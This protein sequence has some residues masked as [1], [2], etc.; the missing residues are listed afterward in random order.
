MKQVRELDFTGEKIFCDIDVHK[1]SWKVCVRNKYMEF[2]TFLQPPSATVLV[3]YLQKNFPS[4]DYYAAYEAGFC[5]F[6]FQRDFIR[7]G[8][9][10]IVVHAADI[11]T[12]DKERHQ[13]MIQ[14]I[15]V[16]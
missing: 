9:N 8:V 14:M 13:K 10:C 6:G 15:V 12:S 3:N 11:P 1:N 5:G 16:K 4:A 7:Q 2:K